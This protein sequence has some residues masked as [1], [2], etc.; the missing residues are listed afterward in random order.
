MVTVDMGSVTVHLARLK[1]AI[2]KQVPQA[3]PLFALIAFAACA[4]FAIAPST[5]AGAIGSTGA[6]AGAAGS[7]RLW[8]GLRTLSCSAG[9]CRTRPLAAAG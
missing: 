6:G 8:P 1:R 9:V 2:A 5:R 4:G 7:Q 3:A